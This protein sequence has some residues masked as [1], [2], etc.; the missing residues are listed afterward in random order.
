MAN[1]VRMPTVVEQAEAKAIVKT[2]VPVVVMRTVITVVVEVRILVVVMKAVFVGVW[3]DRMC[4][5]NI[6]AKPTIV[7]EFNVS[8]IVKEVKVKAPAVMK[9][10]TEFVDVTGCVT[11]LFLEMI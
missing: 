8:G 2:V 11:C 4:T 5:I 6:E 7:T 1:E 10:V 9:A 3:E